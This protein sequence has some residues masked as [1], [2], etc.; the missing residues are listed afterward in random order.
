MPF[1]FGKTEIHDARLLAGFIDEPGCVTEEQ[2]EEWVSCFDSWDLCDQVCNYLFSYTDF[3]VK[4]AIAWIDSE[5]EFI[6][7][8]GFVLMAQLSVHDKKA[9][10]ALFEQFLDMIYEKSG[11]ERNY[12]KK[13][14]NWALRQIGK[15]NLYLN[16]RALHTAEKILLKGDKSSRWVARDAVRELKNE[17]TTAR[18]IR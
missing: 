4:K 14:I 9:G 1:S 16:T 13:A 7:R 11:D 2:M 17:K 3:A 5:S 15:R 18:L 6:K 8:A 10:D 12:V